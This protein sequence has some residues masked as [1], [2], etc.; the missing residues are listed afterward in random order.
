MRPNLSIQRQAKKIKWDMI[1]IQFFLADQPP[2]QHTGDGRW[3]L[4]DEREQ[5][6]RRVPGQRVRARR[7]PP[8]P[9]MPKGQGDRGPKD[10]L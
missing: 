9:E 5:G 8:V 1:M 3:R 10:V 2:A 6:H 7:Q 4:E